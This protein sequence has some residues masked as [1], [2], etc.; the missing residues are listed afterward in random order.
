M[1]ISLLSSLVSVPSPLLNMTWSAQ[2]CPEYSIHMPAHMHTHTQRQY[3]YHF[4][5]QL[6]TFSFPSSQTLPHTFTSH[7]Y[8]PLCGSAR[9]KQPGLSDL[10]TSL[11]FL[12]SP[13]DQFRSA[14]YSL[15]AP[16]KSD[17]PLLCLAPED[18]A[19]SLLLSQPNTILP[20]S[21][22]DPKYKTQNGEYIKARLESNQSSEQRTLKL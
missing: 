21:I 19:S 22:P 11:S 16:S 8:L 12:V 6:I 2:N 18:W 10:L 14:Q 5:I 7:Y 3:R 9:W 13:S 15:S 17:F 20:T 4:G 1:K